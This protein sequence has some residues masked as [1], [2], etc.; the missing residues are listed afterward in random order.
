MHGFSQRKSVM[1]LY[2]WCLVLSALAIAM[3]RAYTPAVVV[4]GVVAVV[5]TAY[6]AR[7]LSRYRSRR[8]GL[9]DPLADRQ[10]DAGEHGG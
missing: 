6:M 1:L 10:G 5:A 4:L 3:Q 7:L 8:R 9:P 2:T